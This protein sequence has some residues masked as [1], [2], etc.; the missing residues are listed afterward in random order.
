MVVAVSPQHWLHDIFTCTWNLAVPHPPVTGCI[1]WSYPP[2]NPSCKFN[3]SLLIFWMSSSIED[4]LSI[5]LLSKCSMLRKFELKWEIVSCRLVCNSM[6]LLPSPSK[7]DP[8]EMLRGTLFIKPFLQKDRLSS[9]TN[10]RCWNDIS[11]TSKHFAKPSMLTTRPYNRFAV[12]IFCQTTD[13][14]VMSRD[15]RCARLVTVGDVSQMFVSPGLKLVKIFLEPS[16]MNTMFGW[17]V[18]LTWSSKPR[19][20]ANWLNSLFVTIVVISLV[21]NK[22]IV[23]DKMVAWVSNGRF[24]VLVKLVSMSSNR[25]PCPKKTHVWSFGDVTMYVSWIKIKKIKEGC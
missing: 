10:I 2:Y 17:L 11:V 8:T 23:L 19:I 9:D 22:K 13:I 1:W 16:T 3:S 15:I 6:I 21:V 4:R 7:K 5:N 25:T 12:W 14:S 24:K 18:M 20:K